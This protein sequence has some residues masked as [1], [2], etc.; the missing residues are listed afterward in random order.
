MS[1]SYPSPPVFGA[2]DWRDTDAYGLDCRVSM[3][4]R[5]DSL[6]SAVSGSLA[7]TDGQPIGSAD[8]AVYNVGVVPSGTI[9]YLPTGPVVAASG[10]FVAWNASGGIANSEYLLT[11]TLTLASSGVLHR[12]VQINTPPYVG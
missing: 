8:L 10:M 7:R 3:T 12:T 5:S 1:G 9:V 6:V 11:L 4:L 2:S